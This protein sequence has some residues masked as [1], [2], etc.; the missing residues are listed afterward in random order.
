MS[1]KLTEAAKTLG[2]EHG[3]QRG[4]WIVETNMSRESAQNLINGYN[5]GDPIWMDLCP[6]PLSGEWAGDPNITTVIDD[7]ANMA[8]A[9]ELLRNTTIE[10]ALDDAQGVL[11]VYEQAFQEAF[12][13]TV[14]KAAQSIIEDVE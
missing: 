12:W 9:D 1:D 3:A 14:I 6:S 4:G 8:E 13:A 7:I 2:A 5:D 10:E 11:D